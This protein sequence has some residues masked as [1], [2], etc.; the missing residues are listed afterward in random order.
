MVIRVIRLESAGVR[1]TDSPGQFMVAQVLCKIR[2]SLLAVL[3]HWFQE[4]MAVL[5]VPLNLP[6]RS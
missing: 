5:T 6:R 1:M 3:A 2:I 4:P